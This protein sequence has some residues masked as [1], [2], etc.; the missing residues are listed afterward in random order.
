[1]TALHMMVPQFQYI[2]AIDQ[3]QITV[4]NFGDD[5]QF[6]IGEIVSFRCSRA[7]GMF[8]I[9]NLSGLVIAITDMT[10]TVD[11]D[12]TNFTPFI[13]PSILTGTTPAI[14]VPSASGI[15]PGSNP[16]T[17]TLFDAF[18]NLRLI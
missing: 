5:H 1:M 8:E 12:S 16:P 3:G 4:I 17:V 9:N 11:I 7:Y 2:T 13:I 15:I 18:D 10:I 14:C 6:S